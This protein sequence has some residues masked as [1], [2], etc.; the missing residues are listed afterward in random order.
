[1]NIEANLSDEEREAEA[2][3]KS[4]GTSCEPMHIPDP[5][6]SL[7][8]LSIVESAPKHDPIALIEKELLAIA[9]ER[10]PDNWGDNAKHKEKVVK[11]NEAFVNY[12]KEMGL[13]HPLE[14]ELF[15]EKLKEPL[16]V[17]FRVNSI[18]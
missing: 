14:W 8:N 11:E 16:G 5:G 12:Y 17:C 15:Y 1:M 2:K 10:A 13:L 7:S 9:K 4:T 18:E 3:S 6:K